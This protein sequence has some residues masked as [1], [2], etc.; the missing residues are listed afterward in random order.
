MLSLTT[1]VAWFTYDFDWTI[2]KILSR[3]ESDRRDSAPPSTKVTDGVGHF[4]A[5]RPL[6][7]RVGQMLNSPI[8]GIRLSFGDHPMMGGIRL[9]FS[10]SPLFP[11]LF[12]PFFP[13]TRTSTKLGNASCAKPTASIEL[14]TG[15]V[16]T[17]RCRSSRVRLRSEP[18]RRDSA[19]CVLAPVSPA[20]IFSPTRRMQRLVFP[21]SGSDLLACM[22]D[23]HSETFPPSSHQAAC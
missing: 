22:V 2:K 15:T 11:R 8:G 4:C 13:S 9:F 14:N 20:I 17:Q 3:S 19:R 1:L 7:T 10:L 21:L 5:G 23:R 16:S 18:L 6:W 12:S